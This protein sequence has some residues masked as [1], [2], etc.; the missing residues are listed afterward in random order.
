MCTLRW[1]AVVWN[2][3]VVWRQMQL[4]EILTKFLYLKFQILTMVPC[5]PPELLP[6]HTWISCHSLTTPQ[7]VHVQGTFSTQTAFTFNWGNISRN[8]CYGLC[9]FLQW[10]NRTKT[11][12]Y[13]CIQRQILISFS[14]F[15]Q[16]Q[17]EE[18]FPKHIFVSHVIKPLCYPGVLWPP[19][20]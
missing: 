14:Y 16:S 9:L 5:Y 10:G 2:S 19:F 17:Q 1:L 8:L 15:T 4:I 13:N 11:T 18:T 6:G 7:N 12:W 3:S 20:L